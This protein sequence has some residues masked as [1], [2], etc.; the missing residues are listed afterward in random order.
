MV[1]DFLDVAYITPVPVG[2]FNNYSDRPRADGPS[3]ANYGGRDDNNQARGNGFVIRGTGGIGGGNFRTERDNNN[4]GNSAGLAY[5]PG[6]WTRGPRLPQNQPNPS[7]W[8][9]S[10][11][12][13]PTNGAERGGGGGGGERGPVPRV[14]G[15]KSRV[16][17][18]MPSS[19]AREMRMF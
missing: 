5:A 9:R 1:G 16:C 6:A 3:T 10:N 19:V 4:G 15:D 18:S 8:G 12:S 17:P 11:D 2:S 7:T 14:W 13:N